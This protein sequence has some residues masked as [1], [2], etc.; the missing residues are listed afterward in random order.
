MFRLNR[1]IPLASMALSM[2]F[3]GCESMP[4]SR[5]GMYHEA[6][7]SPTEVVS[8]S[9]Q[10][11]SSLSL[12][13]TDPTA[14]GKALVIATQD[15][16]EREGKQERLGKYEIVVRPAE[17]GNKSLVTLQRLEGKSKGMRER[18]WYD[19]DVTAQKPSS[20]QQIWEQ[21]KTICPL[22]TQQ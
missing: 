4:T 19:D 16:L 22:P 9:R 12:G 8:Q 11:L 2:V 10:K 1:T 17:S 14:E 3:A 7:C 20:Q 6:S 13:T 15:I 21:I 18:K 5:A